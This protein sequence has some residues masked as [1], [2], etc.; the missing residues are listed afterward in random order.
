MI[1]SLSCDPVADTTT[2]RACLRRQLS[3][4]ER[5]VICMALC[6]RGPLPFY[7]HGGSYCFASLRAYHRP[8]NPASLTNGVAARSLE[9]EQP[10]D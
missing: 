2:A 5:D 3:R 10:C 7:P 6:W 4:P 8:I 1:V 9:D